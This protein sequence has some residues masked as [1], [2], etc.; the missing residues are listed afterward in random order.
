MGSTRIIGRLDR[1]LCNQHCIDLMP[2]SYEYQSLA[3]SDHASMQLHL[4]APSDSG[5]KPFRYFNYC[6]HCP[7]F[8]RVVEQA[9]TSD[10]SRSPNSQ[11]VMKLKEVK[12]EIKEWRKSENINVKACMYVCV[13]VCVYIYL[14][15]L[16]T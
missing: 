3:S 1:I 7:G 16:K 14:L 13:C 9:W 11:V 4:L 15:S 8:K 2:D 6:I 10:I 5:P 12:K